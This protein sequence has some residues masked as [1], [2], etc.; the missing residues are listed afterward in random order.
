[1]LYAGFR[2]GISELETLLTDIELKR[3]Q[4]FWTKMRKAKIKYCSAHDIEY[5][6]QHGCYTCQSEREDFQ[7]YMKR[8]RN[9]NRE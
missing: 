4:A 7:S 1:M 9:V 6:E 2:S 3:L 8:E 5:E